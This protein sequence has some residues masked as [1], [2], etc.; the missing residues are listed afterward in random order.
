M[1]TLTLVH[2]TDANAAGGI[3]RFFACLRRELRRAI[4]IAGE[5][6]MDG[7]MPPL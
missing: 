5:P 1:T 6:Y 2:D 3:S 4:E 7:P